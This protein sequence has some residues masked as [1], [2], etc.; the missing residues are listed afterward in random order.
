[1][2]IT[3]TA[4]FYAPAKPGDEAAIK[5]AWW[6]Q[7][8]DPVTLS[9]FPR[10]AMINWFEWDKYET[11]VKAEVNWTVTQRP[12]LATAFAAALPAQLRWAGSVPDCAPSS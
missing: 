1:M 12:A 7:V 3:E 10:L 11:E 9:R 6:E 8:F 5:Q 4:A 2:A